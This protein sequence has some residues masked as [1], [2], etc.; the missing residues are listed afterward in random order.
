MGD[1]NA[2]TAQWKDRCSKERRLYAKILD[3]SSGRETRRI[4]KLQ[5]VWTASPAVYFL[6]AAD[7]WSTVVF[8]QPSRLNSGAIELEAFTTPNGHFPIRNRHFWKR[9]LMRGMACRVGCS[10]AIGEILE[11]DEDP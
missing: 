5:Q 7:G 8:S 9:K 1:P 2:W 11:N 10:A 3:K 4:R 6:C